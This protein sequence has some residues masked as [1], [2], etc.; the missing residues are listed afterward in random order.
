LNPAWEASWGG[1]IFY[2]WNGIY[3]AACLS[4]FV[5]S[6]SVSATF[7]QAGSED[8]PGV[9][10]AREAVR[11]NP[12]DASLHNTLADALSRDSMLQKNAGSLVEAT[13]EYLEAIR[14]KPDLVEARVNLAAMALLGGQLD[15]AIAE[16]RV[17]LRYNPDQKT[18]KTI[19]E[20]ALKTKSDADRQA[21]KKR[22][23]GYASN[24]DRQA[25]V[26]E[27][28]IAAK[29]GDNGKVKALL[30]KG[31]SPNLTYSTPDIFHINGGEL[32]VYSPLAWAVEAGNLETVTTLLNAGAD[33][34]F[35]PQGGDAPIHSAAFQ[36]HLLMVELLVR[37][38]ADLQ[39]RGSK[40]ATPLHRAAFRGHAATVQVLVDRGAQVNIRDDDGVTPLLEAAASGD[41][42]TVHYLLE[43]GADPLAKANDGSSLREFLN[44]FNSDSK[45][46][47]LWMFVEQWVQ[48]GGRGH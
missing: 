24:Q 27:L 18:A 33:I 32:L 43:Q 28:M 8:L 36:G 47:A 23:L 46:Q 10:E 13:K 2:S 45:R 26:P 34:N 44:P 39:S 20:F 41:F 11:Q 4:L 30:H 22:Q 29:R 9:A 19:M 17:V 48:K 12:G 40:G 35:K 37:K 42:W 15:G 3:V 6:L 1:K 21:A 25:G 38:G 31:I 5:L 7:A 14:L 16:L